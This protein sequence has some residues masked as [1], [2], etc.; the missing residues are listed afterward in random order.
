MKKTMWKLAASAF[1]LALSAG[2][3][4]S[5]EKADKAYWLDIGVRFKDVVGQVARP[6]TYDYFNPDL[7]YS[8][9]LG[10]GMERML[11]EGNYFELEGRFLNAYTQRYEL[12][13]DLSRL[14]KL[15]TSYLDFYHNLDRF[16]FTEFNIGTA[17]WKDQETQTAY[18]RRVSDWKTEIAVSIPAVPTAKVDL[19][20]REYRKRGA[21][22]GKLWTNCGACHMYTRTSGED[23][24]TRDTKAG[25]S[26]TVGGV[27]LE[28]S[29]ENRQLIESYPAQDFPSDGGGTSYANYQ[30]FINN[31]RKFDFVPNQ[32]ANIHDVQARVDLAED[33]TISANYLNASHVNPDNAVKAN[34]T[35]TIADQAYGVRLTKDQLVDNLAFSAAY[36]NFNSNN[37]VYYTFGTLAT[38]EIVVPKSHVSTGELVGLD[39]NIRK[40]GLDASYYLPGP[41][42]TVR[43]KAESETTERGDGLGLS[44]PSID[45]RAHLSILSRCLKDA[46]IQVRYT[47]DNTASPGY[48]TGMLYSHK[49]FG[50]FSWTVTPEFLF[51]VNAGLVMGAGTDYSYQRQSLDYGAMISILPTG[52]PFTFNANYARIGNTVRNDIW[53]RLKTT[54]PYP[55]YVDTVKNYTDQA[56]T[57]AV[58]VVYSVTPELQVDANGYI[59]YSKGSFEAPASTQTNSGK[60]FDMSAIPGYSQL[61]TVTTAL[62]VGMTYDVSKD[63][64]VSLSYLYENYLDNRDDAYNNFS[65]IAHAV[66]AGVGFKF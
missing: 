62:A 50:S 49:G 36:S 48:H 32:T 43:V 4:L 39:L 17:Q 18:G 47:Y 40:M 7:K 31:F 61:D 54:K 21:H 20:Y 16:Q 46:M 57:A 66:Y 63:M 53:Y 6:S 9:L 52:I 58:G 22:Q 59:V 26:G 35:P 23:R 41:K 33:T 14:V 2:V 60:T 51:D 15:E 64:M 3:G 29:F 13:L 37:N 28:Y 1:M 55:A 27:S 19:S 65:G 56:D 8:P 24:V 45:N 44:T 10:F 12:G 5:V 25:I 11:G 34:L 42:T 38:N 30:A